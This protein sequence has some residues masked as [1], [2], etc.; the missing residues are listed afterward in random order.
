M[1]GP[2]QFSE[3]GRMN[4]SWT[5][6]VLKWWDDGVFRADGGPSPLDVVRVLQ[7]SHEPIGY[8]ALHAHTL[9]KAAMRAEEEGNPDFATDLRSAMRF[10]EKVGDT[11]PADTNALVE[12]LRGKA[13]DIVVRGIDS[14]GPAEL[15]D[16]LNE[17]ANKLST[18]VS[19]SAQSFDRDVEKVLQTKPLVWDDNPCPAAK[20]LFGHYVVNPRYFHVELIIGYGNSVVT[21]LGRIELP[22]GASIEDLKDAAQNDLEHRVSAAFEMALPR[23][24]TRLRMAWSDHGEVLNTERGCVTYHFG[25]QERLIEAVKSLSEACDFYRPKVD[26]ADG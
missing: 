5:D 26:V 24:N 10:I 25:T 12:K 17:A 4:R 15:A 21:S 14:V 9:R 23:S 13:G 8:A 18:L 2:V 1:R 20:C 7:T 6:G 19:S 16:L 11:I 22:R 3:N